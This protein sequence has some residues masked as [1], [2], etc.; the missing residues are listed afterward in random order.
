MEGNSF[1]FGQ[2]FIFR[3]L[4][5]RIVGESRLTKSFSI[6]RAFA[7][8][9]ITRQM[10]SSS[11]LY[12]RQDVRTFLLD[13]V[14]A[15]VAHIDFVTWTDLYFQFLIDRK[16][17][18]K[19]RNQATETTADNEYHRLQW[20]AMAIWNSYC[21]FFRRLRSEELMRKI[22]WVRLT[23]PDWFP[24]AH[25]HGIRNNPTILSDRRDGSR[26]KCHRTKCHGQNVADKM[27]RGQ[28]VIRQYATD[29]MSR[30]KCSGQNVVDKIS[31]TKCHGQKVVDSMSLTKWH[32]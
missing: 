9:Q 13:S 15:V 5:G 25:A 31:W 19:S 12:W 32:G 2:V 22:G 17:L 7:I 4:H 14:N 23:N 16:S 8:D 21:L 24:I 20:W 30:T 1:R 3:T 26:T 18:C 27:L 29:T 11:S 10:V 6:S 28:N